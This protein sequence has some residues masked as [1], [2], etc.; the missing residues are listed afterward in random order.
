MGKKTVTP[1]PRSLHAFFYLGV[2]MYPD[3]L[4]LLLLLL[5]GFMNEKDYNG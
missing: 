1:L 4:T 5:P 2:N 3:R